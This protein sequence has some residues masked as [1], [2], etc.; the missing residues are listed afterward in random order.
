MH[1]A[2]VTASRDL[3]TSGWTTP[4]ALVAAVVLAQFHS[5]SLF[6]ALAELFA[7][8]VAMLTAVVGWK[9]YPLSR[10]NFLM[11]LACGYFWVGGLD[12][13][14]LLTNPGTNVFPVDQSNAST[15]LWVGTRFIEALIFLTAP[16]TLGRAL[17]RQRVFHA[18]GLVA[19]LLVAAVAVGVLPDAYIPGHGLTPF[20]VASEYVIVLLLG[21]A[22]L[23][24][25]RQ[26]QRLDARLVRLM[27]ASIALLGAAE[28][29][30][31]LYRSIG[32]W[33][34]VLGHVF[35]LLSYWL[36]YVGIVETTLTQPF[37][38]LARGASTFDA[39]P[40][41]TV[42]V[43][44]AGIVRQGNRAARRFLGLT[45][46]ELLGRHC[47]DLFH[48]AGLTRDACPVCR[49]VDT[50]APAEGLVVELSAHDCW[51]Q[52]SLAPVAGSTNVAA[53]MVHV[54]RDITEQ[55]LAERALRESEARFRE[56][57][58][59]V[60][61]WVWEVDEHNVFTYAS[62]RA[63]DLLGYRPEEVRGRTPFEFM[64]PQEA[65]RVA[66]EFSAIAARRAPF[67]R[68]E[69]TNRRKDGTLVVLETSGAPYFDAQGRFCGYRGLD[70]D[71]TER[72]CIERELERYRDHLEQRVEE[73][74]RELQTLNRELESFSYTVSHDL[75]TPLRAING[76]S[77]ALREDCGGG[78][79]E[80]C[81]AY[82]GHIHDATMRMSDLIDGLLGL[83]RVVRGEMHLE[84]VD[85]SA[86]A[87]DLVRTL[88]DAEPGRVVD[89]HIGPDLGATGD[90]NLLRP[91]LQ[92]LLGNA[93]KFTARREHA[94]IAFDRERRDGRAV[95]FVR[96]NGAG[97]DMR[98][99]HK[100]FE[101]FTRL[102]RQGEYEG[103]GIGLATVRRIVQRHGGAIWAEGEVGVG[104]TF[105][106]TL[107]EAAGGR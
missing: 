44:Q 75:R 69:N 91:L 9:A 82:L 81:R 52:I 33:P 70:R 45:E 5:F 63:F 100:L 83:T 7:V 58:E 64:P 38:T 36:V 43:D 10:N 60:G 105:Y 39:V 94:R 3:D 15:Q 59:T 103:T 62:P 106:F 47:H 56:L 24:L 41:P 57:I 42:V 48:P 101:P 66:A 8:G 104:A 23:L 95:F 77:H 98:H 6:H 53:G 68:L 16:L 13:A 46:G 107:G 51:H 26:R 14:H 86:L 1:S 49:R 54:S 96:D 61:D 92:N 35:K 80:Q 89:L 50:G 4:A 88:A 72:K 84:Q 71:I 30:F 73:R 93:W 102:H 27:L 18:F 25:W 97:F 87:H 29:T 34:T 55:V 2:A 28:L 65:E 99:A 19:V 76:F 11:Y 22:A 74:T 37:R 40:D 79:D 20:K 67:S 31:T 21:A 17:R 78:L 32:E 90:P 12:L 85:L